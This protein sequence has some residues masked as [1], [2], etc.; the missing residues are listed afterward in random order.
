MYLEDQ[1]G[2]IR[3]IRRCRE[4]GFSLSEISGLLS[5]VTAGGR[6]VSKFKS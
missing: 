3:F 1:V 2:N 6:A 5:L 4:L